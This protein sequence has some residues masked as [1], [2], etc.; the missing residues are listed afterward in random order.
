MR[1]E[2]CR[3]RVETMSNAPGASEPATP[4]AAQRRKPGLRAKL[5][6]TLFAL[7]F[8]LLALEAAVRIRHWAKFG[9]FAPVHDFVIDEESGLRLPKPGQNGPIHINSRSFRGAEI[10]DPKPDGRIRIGFLGASTTYCAEV[11]SDAA[12]WPER[13]VAA[14]RARHPEADLDGVNG[15]VPGYTTDSTERNL[16]HRVGPL[17][18]DVLIVYHGTNDLAKD[19]R[20]LA[21]ERGLWQPSQEEESF[22]E[23]VSMAWSLIA[24]NLAIRSRAAGGDD[25]SAG[26]LVFEPAE[27]AQRF[28][29]RLRSLLVAA[30]ERAGVVAVATF[31]HRVRPEQSAEQRA[32]ACQTALYYMPF[33]TPDTVLA[34][35]EAYNEVV[36]RVAREL[37]VILIEGEHRIPADGEHFADSVHFTDAGCEVMAERVVEGLEAA[38]SFRALVD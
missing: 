4:R 14:L 11:S 33:L 21:E 2:A 13:V 22:L 18:P 3:A 16:V 35:V 7:T 1:S 24:K 34:G 26:K 25:A 37:D 19:T 17:D 28:E 8:A 23:R 12:T 29:T 27:L 20:A 32:E 30:K 6:L 5:L 9:S 10:D 15:G 38:P 36:R 31:S